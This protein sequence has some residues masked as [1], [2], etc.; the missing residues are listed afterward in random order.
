MRGIAT[1]LGFQQQIGLDA[2]EAVGDAM[3]DQDGLQRFPDP[4]Y[5]L[6]HLDSIYRI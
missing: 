3:C 6:S 5:A 2:G 4:L 1:H